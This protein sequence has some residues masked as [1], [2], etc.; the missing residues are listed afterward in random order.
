[1]SER[2]VN[3][4]RETPVLFSVD[5]RDWLHEDHLVHFIIEVIEQIEVAGFKVNQRGS[6]SE[7][8]PSEMMLA[9]LVYSYV[10]G[11]F[12]SRMIE[13]ATYTDGVNLLLF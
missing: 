9:L 13:A 4:D 1:M 8:Y 2:F 5:M 10:T 11:R 6:G 7:Q 3:I 12:G